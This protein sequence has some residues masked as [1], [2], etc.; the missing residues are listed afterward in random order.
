MANAQA[1]KWMTEGQYAP[2]PAGQVPSPVANARQTAA[3]MRVDAMNRTDQ[4]NRDAARGIK[5][6]M[7]KLNT[8][9]I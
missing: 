5:A 4:A 3:N 9:N 7:V 1:P 2:T 6:L 8:K